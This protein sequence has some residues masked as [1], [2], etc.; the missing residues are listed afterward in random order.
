MKKI[1]TFLAINFFL[2]GVVELY[3]AEPIDSPSEKVQ[4]KAPK[5]EKV[6]EH[7]KNHF[8]LY[9]FIRNYMSVDTRESKAGTG[10]LFYYLPLDNRWNDDKSQDLNEVTSFRFLAMTSRLGVDVSGYQFGKTH[11]GAKVEADFY[12]GLSGISKGK[13]NFPTSNNITGTAQFRLRQAYLTIGWKDL[14]MGGK[15]TAAVSLKM[16]QAWHPMAADVP[17][18]FSLE[19]GAPF[20]PFSRTPQIT[21]DA[22]LGKNVTLT[23]SLLWQMQYNS[24]GPSG[25]SSTYMKY[26][27]VP[28]A[29]VGVTAKAGGFLAR[30]GADILSIKPRMLGENKAGVEVKVSDRITTLSPYI[31]IQYVN[32][33]FALKAKSIYSSA[34]EHMSLMSG[35]AKVGE[36]EDGSWNYAP[37][38]ATSSWLSLS[39]GKKYQGV[40]FLGYMKNLGL[41]ECATPDNI[42][43]EDM[44]FNGNGFSNINQMLRIEPQFIMTFGK[45]QVGLEYNL[46]GVQYGEYSVID[47]KEYLNNRG[48]ATDNLHWVANHRVQAI[49]KFNF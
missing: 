2:F 26:S 44:Y 6:K 42:L 12:T 47:G 40:L 24:A 4:E 14:P 46:T 35:Y 38:H 10:D 22:D 31:Y 28:E 41:Y 16:G 39:Y 17:H 8:K 21:M 33:N 45:F 36:N 7:L 32:K 5:G 11:F 37:L 9:G 43:K 48:L 27:C 15:N 20:G 30:I 34:G 1:F 3:A 13:E 25:I 19:T 49:F 29:Y 23:A 18:V